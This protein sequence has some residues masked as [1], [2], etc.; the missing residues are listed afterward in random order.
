M[1]R[2][3]DTRR[4][5]SGNDGDRASNVD[6]RGTCG[7]RL[8]A[9]RSSGR[10]VA[11]AAGDGRPA[12]ARFAGR[13]PPPALSLPRGKVRPGVARAACEVGPLRARRRTPSGPRPGRPWPRVRR[14]ARG[15]SPLRSPG[16][17]RSRRHARAGSNRARVRRTRRS[18][19]RANPVLSEAAEPSA[20]MRRGPSRGVDLPIASP[21]GHLEEILR[22]IRAATIGRYRA[23]RHRDRRVRLGLDARSTPGVAR[24]KL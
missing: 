16:D 5:L 13:V 4:Q 19:T 23:L 14:D 22:M 9:R 1:G 15:R 7:H 24:E 21:H 12:Q 17:R 18:A 10:G 8:R 3:S 6:G 2:R 20:A 11:G